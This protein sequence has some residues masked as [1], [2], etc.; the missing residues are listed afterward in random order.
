M[1]GGQCDIFA[2][3]RGFAASDEDPTA[4][5]SLGSQTAGGYWK[6][7]AVMLLR[8][9]SYCCQTAMAAPAGVMAT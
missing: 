5:E 2:R 9:P 6:W 4:G 1:S 8:T 7:L 3:G